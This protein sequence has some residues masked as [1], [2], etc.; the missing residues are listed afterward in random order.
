MK[1]RKKSPFFADVI[2]DAFRDIYLAGE[3]LPKY[4]DFY[5]GEDK[6]NKLDVKK[7][8]II[9]GR[10]G[11]GKTHCLKAFDEKINQINGCKY[12]IYI[13]CLDIVSGSSIDMNGYSQEAKYNHIASLYFKKFLHKFVDNLLSCHQEWI[14]DIKKKDVAANIFEKKILDELIHGSM[15]DSS[16]IVRRNATTSTQTQNKASVGLN[17]T[18]LL[19]GGLSGKYDKIDN[20][21]EIIEQQYNYSTDLSKIR[22]GLDEYLKLCGIKRLYVCID[23]WSELDKSCNTSIQQ[24]FAQKLKQIFLKSQFVSVKIASIWALTEMNDKSLYGRFSGGMELTQDIY[25]TLDLDTLFFKD[26]V[27]IENFLKS[28]LFKRFVNY[29]DD[30][31]REEFCKNDDPE[32]FLIEE[33]FETK[34]NFNI[35]VSAS[36]GVPRDFLELLDRCLLHIGKD[37]VSYSINRNVIEEVS[38]E[39]YLNEKR[40]LISGNNML[41]SF[42]GIVDE[43]LEKHKVRFFV[44]DNNEVKMTAELMELVDKKFLHQLPSSLINRKIRNKYKVFLI[45][46]GCY[47]DWLKSRKIK[48]IDTISPVLALSDEQIENIEN[49]VLE[50]ELTSYLR[51]EECGKTIPL[52][53]PVYVRQRVCYHCGAKIVETTEE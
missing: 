9:F 41:T 47:W 19:T 8:Q 21:E 27:S 31:T 29:C 10:R 37:L 46:Y 13:S 35:L 40:N 30:Q 42:I 36:H 32:N 12:S 50:R 45:D 23:E 53:N 33:I 15:R 4:V 7:N 26:E 39:F 28:L 51:C 18:T 25:K 34:A 24:L 17:L 49:Y 16:Q 52:D 43:Y 48:A 20:Q 2:I 44:V 22:E 38:V 11:T 3:D 1:K 5:A 6:L 14:K